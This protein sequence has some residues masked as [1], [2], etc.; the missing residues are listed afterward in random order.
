[1]MRSQSKGFTLIELMITVAIVGILASVAYPSYVEYVM[2]GKRADAKA[3][4]LENAQ[5][6][7][8]NFTEANSYN[9]TAGGAN[10]SLPISQ[11]PRSGT[12]AYDVGF[13]AGSVAAGSYTLEAKPTGAQA[14]DKCGT[15]TLNHLGQQGIQDA[16]TGMT[17]ANCWQR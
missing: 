11:S 6:L 2:R 7:E 17:A 13:V 14:S 3:V 9:K 10:I 4:L 15:L 5:F 16:S 8:R 1:M 12:K